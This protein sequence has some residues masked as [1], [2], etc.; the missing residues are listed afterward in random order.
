MKRAIGLLIG[1]LSLISTTP[2]LAFDSKACSIWLCLPTGFPSGC[3][4]AK[5]EFKKRITRGKSPLPPFVSCLVKSAP[6]TTLPQSNIT[7]TEGKAAFIPERKKCVKSQIIHQSNDSDRTVCVQFETIAAH[8]IKNTS[9]VV[10]QPKD[11]RPTYSPAGC[12]TTIRYI[13]TY[14]DGK[15]YGDTYYFDSSGN[16]INL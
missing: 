13:D 10:S 14:M 11:G 8:A 15:P 1:T 7:S 9:C 6:S 16:E 12:S 4:E 2:T 5:S 3:G